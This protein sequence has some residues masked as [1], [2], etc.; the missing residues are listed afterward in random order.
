M[1]LLQMHRL[2]LEQTSPKNKK[3]TIVLLL[4]VRCFFM[5]I[6]KNIW[7]INKY[8]S[9]VKLELHVQVMKWLHFCETTDGSIFLINI[10]YTCI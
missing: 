5:F 4:H 6:N 1:Y 9:T 3:K 7:Y 2:K 8:C 10:A